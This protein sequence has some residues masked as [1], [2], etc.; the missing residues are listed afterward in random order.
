MIALIVAMATTITVFAQVNSFTI[1]SVVSGADPMTEMRVH[2]SYDGSWSWAYTKVLYG[3]APNINQ[4]ETISTWRPSGTD[5]FSVLITG[6]APSQT[7]VFTAEILTESGS[8]F[9][10]MTATTSACNFQASVVNNGNDTI[11]QGQ[12]V[13]LIASPA[14][15]TSYAWT[16]NGSALSETSNILT[17]S[18]SGTYM[19]TINDGCVATAQTAV[20]VV[21]PTAMVSTN[22][23]TTFCAGDSITLTANSGNSYLW[24]NGATTQAITV[25]SGGTYNVTVITAT[26]SATSSGV[27]VSAV[28]V[29][30]VTVSNSGS[31]TFCEGSSVQ[32]NANGSATSYLWSN[33]ATTQSITVTQ[34]GTYN[35]MGSN[36]GCSVTSPNVTVTVNPAP[37]AV[38]STNGSTTFCMGGSVDLTASSGDSYQW[39]N[40][41]TTQTVTA[42]VAGSYSVTVTSNGCLATSNPVSVSTLTTGAVV[43]ASGPTTFCEG[44]SVTLYSSSNFGNLW[45]NGVETQS[46][47]VTQG[48]T[49]NVV[50]SNGACQGTSNPVTVTVI[51]TQNA[52]VITASGSTSFCQGGSV[53]LST[54]GGTT[55]VWNNG[56]T[57][58]SIQVNQTGNY[59][60]SMTDANGCQSPSSSV[61]TVTVNPTPTPEI[62]ANGPTIFCQGGSVSLSAFGSGTYSWNNG[63][64]GN[65]QTVTASASGTY[66]VTVTNQFGCAASASQS[67]TVNPLPTPQVTANGS[68]T[69]CEGG[70]VTLTASGSGNHTWSTGHI[71]SSLTVFNEGSYSVSMVDATGCEGLSNSLMVWVNPNPEVGIMQA[72]PNSSSITANVFGGTAPY[73]YLW[74]T[75]DVTPSI[76][77][78]QNGQYGVNVTDANGC[79]GSGLT[80]VHGVGIEEIWE[81]LTVEIDHID[82]HDLSGRKIQSLRT[83]GEYQGLISGSYILRGYDREGNLLFTEKVYK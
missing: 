24:N 28:S 64:L 83:G 58:S 35:V 63:S 12:S 10:V 55:Y 77:V 36:G 81:A 51:P 56:D 70:S 72:G 59:S 11:C 17:V 74:S 44:G 4:D 32:L 38:I 57:L 67:V 13:S 37:T 62:S 18:Q 22:G 5:T 68:T 69:F 66:T 2:V 73:E 54:T 15:A 79:S 52:P 76:L 16:R 9:S 33:G 23:P 49:Y 41:A 29:P 80:S 78:F 60:V 31:T 39:S 7:Y 21:S 1:D 40:G 19:V 43:T 30:T 75:G 27:T 25:N 65:A 8:E 6:L 46:I 48:G 20:T 34:G 3:I 82:V 45:N 53:L 14:G 50:V 26:C 71:G 42:S 47:T 61:T